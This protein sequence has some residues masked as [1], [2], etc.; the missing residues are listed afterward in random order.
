MATSSLVEMRRRLDGY[1]SRVVVDARDRGLYRDGLGG[2]ITVD[3]A[4][5]HT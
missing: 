5:R 2:G 4:A 1:G 3:E